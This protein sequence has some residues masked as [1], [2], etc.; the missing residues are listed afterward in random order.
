MEGGQS[1]WELIMYRRQVGAAF[2]T[3][4]SQLPDR[5]AWRVERSLQVHLPL[6]SV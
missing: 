4:T 1:A 3:V 6:H 5:A 2:L